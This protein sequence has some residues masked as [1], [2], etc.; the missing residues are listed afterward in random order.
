MKISKRLLAL[1]L[2]SALAVSS[3]VSA[4]ADNSDS[5]VSDGVSASAVY[6]A[7][8]SEYNNDNLSNENSTKITAN[9]GEKLSLK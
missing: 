1:F 9:V 6:N 2:I 8:N 7:V 4:G 5:S 3:S